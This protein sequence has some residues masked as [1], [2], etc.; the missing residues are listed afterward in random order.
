MAKPFVDVNLRGLEN[1]RAEIETFRG[2]ARQNVGRA[3]ELT[4]GA[5][6][7]KARRN[8]RG[9]KTGRT[10]RIGGRTHQASAP[11]EGP[12]IFSRE[13]FRSIFRRVEGLGGEVGSDEEKAGWLEFGVLRAGGNLMERRPW[14]RPA[15]RSERK[16]WFRRLR[17]ALNKAGRTAR[18]QGRARRGR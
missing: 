18:A 13:L 4:T 15:V 8:M 9:P 16:T 17:R 5:V 14:L 10:Y 1:M 11:K 6:W 12:A 7:R 3:V 2:E